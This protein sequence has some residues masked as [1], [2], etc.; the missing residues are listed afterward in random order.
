VQWTFDALSRGWKRDTTVLCTDPQPFHGQYQHQSSRPSPYMRTC[1]SKASRNY[2]EKFLFACLHIHL[3]LLIIRFCYRPTTHVHC[4][5]KKFPPLNYL[6]LSYLNRFSFFLHCWKAHDNIHLT[7]GMLLHYLGKL[8]IDFCR[9]GRKRFPAVQKNEN[10][11]RFDTVTES[12]KVG[13]FL[14]H[15][16]NRLSVAYDSKAI[17]Q[18]EALSALLESYARRSHK[19]VYQNTTLGRRSKNT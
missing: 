7:L 11:L 5:F 16:V 12:L 2:V 3:S 19:D 1:R 6:Y 4:V 13:T 10:W 9:C 14:R 18:H 8:K 17:L 15:S